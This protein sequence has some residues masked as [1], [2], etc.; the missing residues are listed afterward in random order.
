MLTINSDATGHTLALEVG[1]AAL[2]A[3][4][5]QSL[6]LGAASLESTF[7]SVIGVALC[8]SLG[9]LLAL[10]TRVGGREGGERKNEGR[11]EVHRDD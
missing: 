6:E 5:L 10:M 3:T 4:L 11:A 2:D 1:H 9:G 7:V 8:E